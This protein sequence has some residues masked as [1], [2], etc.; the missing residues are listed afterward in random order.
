MNAPRPGRVK[1]RILLFS[2]WFAPGYKGGGSLVAT[3]NLV[4]ALRDTFEFHVVTRD[5]DVGDDKAYVSAN[6]GAWTDFEGIATRYLAPSEQTFPTIARIIRETPHDL[7]H[8]NSIVSLPF[9]FYP[10]LARRLGLA[11]RKPLLISPHGEAAPRALAQKARRKRMYLAATQAMKV[12]GD[13]VWQALSEQE[14]LDIQRLFGPATPVTVTAPLLPALEQ[15]KS[16]RAPKQPGRLRAV[17]LSRIDRMKNLDVA[18]RLV[19]ATDCVSLDIYGPI[20][21]PDYWVECQSL[22]ASGRPGAIRYRG[23][24]P[25]AEVQK[26]LSGYDLMILPSQSE[27]FGFVVLEALASACPVLVS[28]ATPWRGLAALGIGADL[29]QADLPAFGAFLRDIVALDEAAHR[30]MRDRARR[31]ALDY[32]GRSTAGNQAADLYRRLLTRL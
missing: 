7:V 29:P 3:V 26:V 9:A 23:G 12:F 10:L 28:N 17:F 4:R 19:N 6:S 1:P 5:R 22:I 21:Q 32:A 16:V 13:A 25:P 24:L 8:L 2:N 14:M 18:I 27:N 30:Q 31:Y 11:E 20:G 15:G